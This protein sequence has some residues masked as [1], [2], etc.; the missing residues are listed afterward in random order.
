MKKI[1][2]RHIVS[3]QTQW[4]PMTVNVKKDS[5]KGEIPALTETSVS[6]APPV[7]KMPPAKM[8]QA[9]SNVTVTA[10]SLM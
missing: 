10:G 4:D 7:A 2:A 8:S 5:S 1:S 6:L 9:R 3:A